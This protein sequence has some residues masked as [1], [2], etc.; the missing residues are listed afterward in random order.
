M[1]ISCV[2]TITVFAVL[3]D[4]GLFRNPTSGDLVIS[5]DYYNNKEYH[6]YSLYGSKLRSG[7]I[8]NQVVSFDGLPAGVYILNIDGQVAKVMKR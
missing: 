8:R 7:L 2:T 3:D 4:C 5:K 6:V 1:N